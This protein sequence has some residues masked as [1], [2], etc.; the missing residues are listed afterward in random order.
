[1]FL[2]EDQLRQAIMAHLAATPTGGAVTWGERNQIM[3]ALSQLQA[4]PASDASPKPPEPPG[5]AG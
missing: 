4:A 3:V 5:R 1:M 2:I